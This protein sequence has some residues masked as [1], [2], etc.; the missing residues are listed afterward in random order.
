MT[1]YRAVV[2]YDGSRY[3]GFQIQGKGEVTVQG[4]LEAVLAKL[5]GGMIR[6]DVAGRTD[7][8]VHASGQVISFAL[9]WPHGEER[10]LRAL[11][12][13][14]PPD[15]AV[16][17]VQPA[18]ERFHARFSAK[19]RRYRYT[20]L[21]T[22]QPH[23]LLGARAWHVPQA[24]DLAA[25]QAAA[26]LLIGTADFGAFGRAPEDQGHTVRSVYVAEWSS[27]ADALSMPTSAYGARLNAAPPLVGATGSDG[28]LAVG[29]VYQYVTEA[30][31]FLQHMV[32]RMAGAMVDVGRGRLTLAAFRSAFERADPWQYKT[33]AP[34][35]GLVLEAVFY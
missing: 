32:R 21:N 27:V 3:D 6:L 2:A 34:P 12:A 24:L 11:N 8:G 10:L 4:V 18:P 25:M 14:L 22:Q 15:V 28:G 17:Q 20:V 33:L 7:A 19:S 5:S 9:T 30:N 29:A 31:A 23:P 35:Q 13:N 26:Q 1:L 16:L